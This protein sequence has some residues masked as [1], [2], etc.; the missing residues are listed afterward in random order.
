MAVPISPRGPAVATP[1]TNTQN[2]ATVPAQ[3]QPQTFNFM[4]Q[5]AQVDATGKVI[6]TAPLA[7]S[8]NSFD[9]TAKVTPIV[10]ANA[11]TQD[12]LSK[13][14]STNQIAQGVATQAQTNAQNKAVTDANTQAQQQPK[15]DAQ[16]NPLPDNS[17]LT[18]ALNN[19]TNALNAGN[20]QAPDQDSYNKTESDLGDQQ[21][22]IQTKLDDIDTQ[23][24]TS[25]DQ[26]QQSVQQIQ[27]GSFPLTPAQGALLQQTQTAMQGLTQ[28]AQQNAQIYGQMATTFGAV[29]G[30][31]QFN[32]GAVQ[33]A[34]SAS[35]AKGQAEIAKAE[36]DGTKQLADLQKGFQD[37]DFN[38]ISKSY[39]ALQNSLDSKQKILSDLST[40]VQKQ[41]SDATDQY[42]KQVTQYK[43]DVQN[44]ITNSF[45][46][47]ELDDSEK[48]T[49]FDQAMQSANFDEKQKQDIQDNYFKGQQLNLDA[50]KVA[51]SQQDL[52]LKVQQAQDGTNSIADQVANNIQTTMS[53]KSYFDPSQYTGK[54][55]TAAIA[56]ATDLG[57]PIVTKDEAATLASSDQVRQ[58]NQ[59]ITNYLSDLLP[60]DAV[61]RITAA[62][63]TKLA[64]VFQTDDKKAAFNSFQNAAIQTLR[65]LAGSKG[66]RINQAEITN[67]LANDVPALT[68][69]LGTANQKIANINALLDN[70][71]NTILTKNR[72]TL[73]GGINAPQQTIADPPKGEINVVDNKTGQ[74]GHIPVSEYD[75]TKYHKYQP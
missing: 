48:K 70:S 60:K 1:T 16:G 30:L 27:N 13:Q 34:V 61:G 42:N 3:V 11:A 10:S 64:K 38:M 40:Q 73:S 49:V 41:I 71:D 63:G 15:T 65:A 2:V 25:S 72:S 32:P 8:T 66:L 74:V 39:D 23:I 19:A 52:A 35:M 69:T 22:V 17:D 56:A 59:T 57:A 7:P 43:T 45:K 68:D 31:S 33:Q 5:S 37:D 54:D 75:V 46:G 9:P 12:Y 51:I 44:A 62:P 26:F 18:G 24:G 47:Q 58:N 36:M 14:A 21:K 6:S 67:A 55:K 29:H 50:Q 28:S 20:I 4:N 53:G